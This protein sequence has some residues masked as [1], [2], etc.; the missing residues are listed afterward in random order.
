MTRKE[1]LKAIPYPVEFGE[2]EKDKRDYALAPP[3][4]RDCPKAISYEYQ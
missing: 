3:N 2:S 4:A 1:Q